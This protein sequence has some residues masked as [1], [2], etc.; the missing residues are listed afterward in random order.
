M[1]TKKP[2]VQCLLDETVFKKLKVLADKENRSTS[3]I[4]GMIVTKYI[5]EYEKE[6][7]KI[8][9]PPESTE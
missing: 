3:N 1:P 4:A 5:K 9:I 6:H 7:G 2:V 8:E